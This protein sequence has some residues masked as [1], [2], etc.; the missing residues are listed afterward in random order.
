MYHTIKQ[1]SLYSWWN[2]WVSNFWWMQSRHCILLQAKT[3]RKF[4]TKP[5]LTNSL[6][7]ALAYS[8]ASPP[9]WKP[10]HA[11]SCQLG[12]L[13]PEFFRILVKTS[14]V[15]CL[16]HSKTHQKNLTINKLTLNLSFALLSL[17]SHTKIFLPQSKTK[18]SPL[19]RESTVRG[20]WRN[21]FK[22]NY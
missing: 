9:K 13:L 20:T 1:N 21:E 5:L 15:L 17:P 11:K 12:R 2:S 7:A 4:A 19:L 14:R 3:A 8:T 16:L 18:Q 6:T 22:I 10:L